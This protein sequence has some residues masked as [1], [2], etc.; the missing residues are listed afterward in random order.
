MEIF[1]NFIH[2]LGKYN[3]PFK[4]TKILIFSSSFFAY[5]YAA[6]ICRFRDVEMR[7]REK[8]SQCQILVDFGQA[9]S[10]KQVY[11]I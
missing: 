10:A 3:L 7:Y 11:N 8:N 6:L 2:S 5:Y 4:S 9:I 1:H